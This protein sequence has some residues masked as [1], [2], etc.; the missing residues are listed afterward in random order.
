MF[1]IENG[2]S[3]FFQWDIKQRLIVEDASIEQVH[4]CNR[5]DDC[6]LKREVYNEGGKR[7]VDFT[8]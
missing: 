4:F 6:S 8:L 5:T 1:L 2:R 7:I 3:Q